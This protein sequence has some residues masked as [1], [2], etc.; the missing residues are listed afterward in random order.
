MWE[1]SWG[2][3][4]LTR[5]RRLSSEERSTGVV[6]FCWDAVVMGVKEERRRWAEASR[7]GDGAAEERGRHGWLLQGEAGGGEQGDQAPRD[8]LPSDRVQLI[9]GSK[10]N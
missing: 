5:R 9:C 1:G 7:R 6:A 4:L 10:D 3:H 8:A 2:A